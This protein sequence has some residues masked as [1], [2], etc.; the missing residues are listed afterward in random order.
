MIWKDKK[1]REKLANLKIVKPELAMQLEMYLVQLY[2]A[3]QLK[4]LTEDQ[5][6]SIL[7]RLGK[8]R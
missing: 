6:I 4:H 2:N 7:S 3:G 8:K 1:A 5:L